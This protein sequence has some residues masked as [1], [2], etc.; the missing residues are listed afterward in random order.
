LRRRQQSGTKFQPTGEG[1]PNHGHIG[2]SLQTD[3]E[4]HLEVARFSTP[5]EVATLVALLA[6]P[7]T[8]TVT[9]ATR[10]ASPTRS[11]E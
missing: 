2:T 3:A 5:E 6:S 11:R 1:T 10:D 8:A 7:R 4:T 9:G